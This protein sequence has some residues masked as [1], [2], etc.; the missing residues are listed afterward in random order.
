MRL[1]LASHQNKEIHAMI[2]EQENIQDTLGPIH[3]SMVNS[4]GVILHKTGHD[5]GIIH[6][7]EIFKI[8]H[9]T[10]QDN[11]GSS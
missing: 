7:Y 11:T 2:T 3:D 8:K 1:E 10:G 4:E 5:R 9:L 6:D